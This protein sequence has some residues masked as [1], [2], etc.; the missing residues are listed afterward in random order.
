[1]PTYLY[2]HHVLTGAC[3]DQRKL[4]DEWELESQATTSDEP[5]SS[6]TVESICNCQ[7]TS[8]AHFENAFRW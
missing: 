5:K 1:M 8:P 7:A 3:R 2:V 6:A 4:S